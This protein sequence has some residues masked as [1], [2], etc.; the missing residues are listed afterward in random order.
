M[1]GKGMPDDLAPLR[2]LAV[3]SASEITAVVAVLDQVKRLR[4]KSGK[5]R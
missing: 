5:A 2:D 4:D 3:S 1:A